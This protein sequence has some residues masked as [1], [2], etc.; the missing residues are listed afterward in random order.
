MLHIAPFESGSHLI[1]TD[2]STYGR[3]AWGCCVFRTHCLTKQFRSRPICKQRS[4]KKWPGCRIWCDLIWW[5]EPTRKM[6][7]HWKPSP[8]SGTPNIHLILGFFGARAQIISGPPLPLPPPLPPS[9][10]VGSAWA[11]AA[12]SRRSLSR[13]LSGSPFWGADAKMLLPGE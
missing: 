5:L 2:P 7:N 10:C 1:Q 6:E 9:P 12:R 8:S 3:K 13:R 4:K 11:P